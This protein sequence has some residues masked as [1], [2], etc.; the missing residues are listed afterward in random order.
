MQVVLGCMDPSWHVRKSLISVPNVNNDHHHL[1]FY[2]ACV[3]HAMLESI[4]YLALIYSIVYCHPKAG[5]S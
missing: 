5:T 4:M 2:P 1:Q 3:L